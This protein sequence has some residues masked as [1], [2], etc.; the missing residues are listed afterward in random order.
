VKSFF[1]IEAL[2]GKKEVIAKTD[3]AHP[4]R[5]RKRENRPE[6]E[7]NKWVRRSKIIRNSSGTPTLG[8]K[9]HIENSKTNSHTHM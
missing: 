4:P 3:S 7:K 1:M 2:L 6:E 9:K 8:E 5:H